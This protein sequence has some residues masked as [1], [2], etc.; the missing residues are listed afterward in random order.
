[1]L[2]HGSGKVE[3][4]KAS[5]S[6]GM[7]TVPTPKVASVTTDAVFLIQEGIIVSCP[8]LEKAFRTWKN[9]PARLVGFFGYRGLG[10]GGV[11]PVESGTGSYAYV[12]DRAVFTHKAYLESFPLQEMATDEREGSG[13]SCCDD[14]SLSLKV[15]LAMG[16]S[17]VVLKANPVDLLEG[18]GKQRTSAL[19]RTTKSTKGKQT[20]IRKRQEHSSCN[21]SPSWLQKHDIQSIPHSHSAVVVTMT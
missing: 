3:P 11:V 9:D 7:A 17:P 16:R 4:A 19:H 14:I 2:S 18:S 1:L 13:E 12:A 20:Q 6:N 21:C 10:T 15:S 5:Q 8:E